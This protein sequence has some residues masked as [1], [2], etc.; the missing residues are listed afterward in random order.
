MMANSNRPNQTK[1]TKSNQLYQNY[2]K[3]VYDTKP[4]KVNQTYQTNPKK[5]NKM[6]APKLNSW[7]AIVSQSKQQGSN[8]S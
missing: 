1:P 7:L 5:R 2:Q 3:Q 6:K 4:T 8:Q